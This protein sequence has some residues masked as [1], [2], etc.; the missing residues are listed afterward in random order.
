MTRRCCEITSVRRL[1]AIPQKKSRF[2][3]GTSKGLST[4][5]RILSAGSKQPKHLAPGDGNG[6][7]MRAIAGC[8]IGR[9]KDTGEGHGVHDLKALEAVGGNEGGW[10]VL[11]KIGQR[12]NG[13]GRCAMRWILD[14]ARNVNQVKEL[15]GLGKP[16]NVSCRAKA[17][18]KFFVLLF[19]CSHRLIGLWFPS[20]SSVACLP[21]GSVLR[22]DRHD[23]ESQSLSTVA[24]EENA[25]APLIEIG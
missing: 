9:S 17:R 11:R 24:G 18:G 22:I 13:I 8:L 5:D 21:V 6:S 10:I 1:L 4:G 19:F 16:S 20:V 12:K 25:G 2:Q 3:L 14:T 15:K 23:G 7:D